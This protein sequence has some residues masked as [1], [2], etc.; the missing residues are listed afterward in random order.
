MCAR[1]N[2]TIFGA[3]DNFQQVSEQEEE[4]TVIQLERSDSSQNANIQRDKL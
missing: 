1:W 3:D 2:R 4:I